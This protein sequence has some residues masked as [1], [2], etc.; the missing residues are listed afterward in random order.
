MASCTLPLILIW[1]MKLLYRDPLDWMVLIWHTVT[2]P[3]YLRVRLYQDATL[4]ARLVTMQSRRRLLAGTAQILQLQVVRREVLDYEDI[5]QEEMLV[6]WHMLLSAVA[7]IGMLVWLALMILL[8]RC[9]LKKRRMTR[10]MK[11][12]DR[13]RTISL[14]LRSLL[15]PTERVRH[16]RS[17]VPDL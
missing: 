12:L 13:A 6:T 2:A 7:L 4:R 5:W 3:G 9:Y 16:K 8:T 14:N 10:I 17:L 1:I 11:E 15:Q